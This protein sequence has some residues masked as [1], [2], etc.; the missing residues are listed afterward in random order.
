MPL[1]R[2]KLWERKESMEAEREKR[3]AF[4]LR[5]IHNQI[6]HFIHRSSPRFEQAPKTQLQGGILGYLYHHQDQPVYQRYLEKE[7][8]ISRA[9][10]TNTL[11]VMERDGLVVRRALDKDARLKR[12]QMTDEAF[13]N[14]MQIEAHMEMMDSRMIEGMSEDEAAQLRRLLGILQKNLEKMSAELDGASEEDAAIAT[15]KRKE[16]KTESC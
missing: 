5:E 11:Q 15:R 10:A 9:T 2:E 8:C 13:R 3:I 7:F 4:V 14:H 1:C 16:G 12:I 6:K